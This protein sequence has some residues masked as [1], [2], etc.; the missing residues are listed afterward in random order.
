MHMLSHSLVTLWASLHA[1]CEPICCMML[2]G[3]ASMDPTQPTTPSHVHSKDPVSA[4]LPSPVD[5]I[6]QPNVSQLLQSTPE[7]APSK[8]GAQPTETLQGPVAKLTSQAL[9]SPRSTS[10]QE[11]PR[12]KSSPGS[13]IVNPEEGANSR[14]GRISH[15]S[16]AAEEAASGQENTNGEGQTAAMDDRDVSEVEAA[17]GKT[18]PAPDMGSV[19]AS[20]H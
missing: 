6:M 13:D 18:S 8:A 1:N 9:S 10:A 3:L 15:K 4:S 11:S 7:A 19:P 12:A 16:A 5:P 2:A 17:A 14:E 20:T